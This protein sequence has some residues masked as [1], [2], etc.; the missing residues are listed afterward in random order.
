MKKQ[1]LY[2]E[3]QK[4]VVCEKSYYF[5]RFFAKEPHKFLR[6]WL[7]D[8]EREFKKNLA[9][10]DFTKQAHQLGVL[11]A[12]HITICNIDYFKKN[13]TFDFNQYFTNIPTK[14]WA[15]FAY[16]IFQSLQGLKTDAEVQYFFEELYNI[17]FD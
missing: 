6:Y 7:K 1:Y 8:N 9:T 2:T 10:K 16:Y 17:I 4:Q 11:F 15:G 3:A 5:G 12:Y 14:S 13:R